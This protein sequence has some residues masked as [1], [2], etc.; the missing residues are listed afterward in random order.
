MHLEGGIP[1]EILAANIEYELLEVNTGFVITVAENIKQTAIDF[2]S[3]LTGL[4]E[5]GQDQSSSAQSQDAT[6]NASDKGF[7]DEAILF[8]PDVI[9]CDEVCHK[10]ADIDATGLPR[11][12]DRAANWRRM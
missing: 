8:L 2:G 11:I 9:I 1:F 10:V 5:T 4:T 12:K 6:G 7:D 3:L